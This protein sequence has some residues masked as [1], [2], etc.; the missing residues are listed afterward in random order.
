M[1]F[2]ADIADWELAGVCLK[3]T[4]ETQATAFREQNSV[5]Q[6]VRCRQVSYHIEA[7]GDG[8]LKAKC[9]D[10]GF[11]SLAFFIAAEISA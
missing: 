8:F 6:F 5:V 3:A 7:N 11:N 1:V 10:E 9:S 2:S 4:V